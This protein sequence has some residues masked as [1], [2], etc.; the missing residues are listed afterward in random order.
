MF[1]V[2][3]AGQTL[4]R[5]RLESAHLLAFQVGFGLVKVF[6]VLGDPEVAIEDLVGVCVRSLVSAGLSFENLPDTAFKN[7][8]VPL[9]SASVIRV[10]ES[11][12]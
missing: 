3:Q 4:Q 6:M 5:G 12:D 1:I 9:R 8:L 11:K 2:D 10:K 7:C